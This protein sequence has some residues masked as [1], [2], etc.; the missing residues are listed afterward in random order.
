MD[1]PI[2]WNARRFTEQTSTRPF[3]KPS[4][5]LNVVVPCF[6]LRPFVPLQMPG[7]RPLAIS[8]NRVRGVVH[9]SAGSRANAFSNG[10]QP[11]T[12][13]TNVCAVCGCRYRAVVPDEKSPPKHANREKDGGRG[14][15][16]IRPP[17]YLRE[18]V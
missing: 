11:W 12:F 15:S 9:L 8:V 13:A 7:R 10:F 1:G 5:R 3:S 16:F 17:P 4:T 14:F 6:R 18:N 2:D